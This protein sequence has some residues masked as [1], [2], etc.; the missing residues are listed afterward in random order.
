[1]TKKILIIVS[2]LIIVLLAGWFYNQKKGGVPEDD[3]LL[4]SERAAQMELV[5]ISMEGS[6][7]RV[8]ADH[9]VVSTMRIERTARGGEPVSYEKIVRFENSVQLTEAGKK[10][11]ISGA[12]ALQNLK[13]RDRAV[14]YG[15]GDT[16]TMTSE[17]FTATKVDILNRAEF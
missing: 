10:S 4:A 17:E 8:E 5:E 14:F 6:V 13:P 9:L 12:E 16:N 3:G 7:M 11:E 2:L 1:M 15:S